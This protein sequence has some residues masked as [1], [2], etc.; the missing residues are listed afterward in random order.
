MDLCQAI[1]AR[2]YWTVKIKRDPVLIYHS[3]ETKGNGSGRYKLPVFWSSRFPFVGNGPTNPSQ[4]KMH[5]ASKTLNIKVTAN[6]DSIILLRLQKNYISLYSSER[7]SSDFNTSFSETTYQQFYRVIGRFIRR[8]TFRWLRFPSRYFL[9]NK[10]IACASI[11][12]WVVVFVPFK[13]VF[14][15]D[16]RYFEKLPKK[17]RKKKH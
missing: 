5:E 13:F 7:V 10:R 1:I 6:F 15:R 12:G 14:F 11:V 17:R 3:Y 16:A 8:L 2:K 9:K 4:S